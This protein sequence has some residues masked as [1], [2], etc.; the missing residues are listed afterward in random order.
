MLAMPQVKLESSRQAVSIATIVEVK[1]LLPARPAGRLSG[2]HRVGRE[3]RGEHDDVAEQ[4]DPEAVAD[5]DAL[6]D[7]SAA[8]V[9]GQ[10][11]P[12]RARHVGDAAAVRAGIARLA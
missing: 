6:V 12:R 11:V 7:R 8:G 9:R 3:E 10:R 5:D 2:Q 1:Q 4:E